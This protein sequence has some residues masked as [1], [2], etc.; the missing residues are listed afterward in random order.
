MSNK[1]KLKQLAFHRES[2]EVCW[3]SLLVARALTPSYM[4][5]DDKIT[6]LVSARLDAIKH[7]EKQLLN[8][9]SKS[10]QLHKL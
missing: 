8:S 5:W 7:E 1:E 3:K 9:M 6:E 10:G 4:G 2:L